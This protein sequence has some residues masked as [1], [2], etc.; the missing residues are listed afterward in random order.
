MTTEKAP[1]PTPAGIR[2][3]EIFRT[4]ADVDARAKETLH[5]TIDEQAKLAKAMVDYAAEVREGIR[6]ATL[7]AFSRSR[8]MM[9]FW[10]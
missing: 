2:P 1:N 4:F 6:K 5:R 7:D 9:R 3:D 10:A 8:E